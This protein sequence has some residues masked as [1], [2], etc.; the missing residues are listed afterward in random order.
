[1]S[2]VRCCLAALLVAPALAGCLRKSAPE[3]IYL[4]HLA[5]LSGADRDVGE[6]ARQGVQLAVED[7]NEKP[8][9]G[10]RVA[11]LHVDSRAGGEVVRAEAV[12]LVTVN[13]VAALL[14]GPDAVPA[15]DVLRAARPYDVP[16]VIPG[17][18]P[19]PP[20]AGGI[21]LGATPAYRGRVLARYAAQDLKATRATV[22]TDSRNPVAARLAT[23]FLKEWHRASKAAVPEF[24]YE[25]KSEQDAAAGRAAGAKPEVI[26]IAAPVRDFRSLLDL[27]RKGGSQAAVLYGGPDVG[28]G[29]LHGAEAEGPGLY[30]ATVYAA[31]GLT[32]RGQAFARRYEER[33]HEAPDLYAAQAHDGARL[34]FET[35]QKLQTADGALV[36]AELSKGETFESLTGPVKWK[37]RQPR[38]PVFLVRLHKG[39]ADLVKKLDP[40][41]E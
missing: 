25:S 26:L 40:E 34:L 14:A 21:C 32:E 20:A 18:L 10:R 17:E 9:A 29:P 7:A 23:A 27:V 22:L 12:R 41:G 19:D 30:L 31:E 37:D 5:P 15:E 13:K 1:M 35:M 8:V 11:V 16:V 3:P 39:K 6:H 38:R 4:G 33:F 36:W 24:T 28:A 2:A